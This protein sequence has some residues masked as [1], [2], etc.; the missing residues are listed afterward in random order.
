[1]PALF[2]QQRASTL[3]RAPV[4]LRSERCSSWNIVLSGFFPVGF[5]RAPLG[6]VCA[7]SQTGWTK[8]STKPGMAPSDPDGKLSRSD[9][10]L[11]GDLPEHSRNIDLVAG[12][13]TRDCLPGGGPDRSR[14]RTELP[15]RG[16]P[17]RARVSFVEI[18]RRQTADGRPIFNDTR[19]QGQTRL[20]DAQQIDLRGDELACGLEA[21]RIGSGAS[22]LAGELANALGHCRIAQCRHGHFAPRAPFPRQC[23]GQCWRA[24]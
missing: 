11:H 16:L 21:L 13:F 19:E 10:P 14:R 6:F 1:L 18:K 8:S 2:V 20:T 5:V 15:H 12:H 22:E 4:Y 24:H 3:W 17:P 9:C 7:K 23:A